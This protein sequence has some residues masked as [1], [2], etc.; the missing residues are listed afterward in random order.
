MHRSI[1]FAYIAT[2]TVHSDPEANE[3]R[4]LRR[5]AEARITLRGYEGYQR[6]WKRRKKHHEIAAASGHVAWIPTRPIPST[7]HLLSDAFLCIFF[8]HNGG[9][10]ASHGRPV[11]KKRPRFRNQLLRLCWPWSKFLF[12]IFDRC[13]VPFQLFPLWICLPGADNVQFRDS[14]AYRMLSYETNYLFAKFSKSHS[15]RIAL[16]LYIQLDSGWLYEI[17]D[18]IHLE[19]TQFPIWNFPVLNIHSLHFLEISY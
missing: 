1:S 2:I 9:T 3:N 15:K 5:D 7:F 11:T 6:G 13:C 8:A 10:I 14:N 18:R 12:W 4:S 17:N 19:D 16:K